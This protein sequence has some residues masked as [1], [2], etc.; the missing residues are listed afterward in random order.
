MDTT[1]FTE[2]A[3]VYEQEADNRYHE[4]EE[5]IGALLND[6]QFE[7]LAVAACPLLK[8]LTALSSGT[9]R[10]IQVLRN[11][12]DKTE[13]TDI[14]QFT[15]QSLLLLY[16]RHPAVFKMLDKLDIVSTEHDLH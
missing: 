13:I 16:I 5:K 7:L 12:E 4:I 6:Q 11:K 10:F 14:M 15:L 3:S 1:D 2:K 9:T 8:D